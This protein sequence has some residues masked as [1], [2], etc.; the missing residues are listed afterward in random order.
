[1]SR[2]FKLRDFKILEN[3]VTIYLFIFKIHIELNKKDLRIDTFKASGPGGQ[4]VNTTDRQ[5][6]S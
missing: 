6:K 3:F 5:V 4:A 2:L 1:L